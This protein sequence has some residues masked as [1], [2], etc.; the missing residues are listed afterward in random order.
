MIIKNG[1]VFE[2]DFRF[3]KRDV[4][5]ENGM[6]AASENELSNFDIVDATGHYVLPGLIDIHSHGACGHDFSDGDTEGLR[7]ILAYERSCGI[8]SYC[9]TS[10]TLPN[11]QLIHIFEEASKLEHSPELAHI[12]GFNMEGPFLDYKKKGA[13]KEEYIST[14]YV[15]FFQECNAASNYRIRLV[16]LAP[17]RKDSLSFIQELHEETNISLGHTSA[18]YETCKKAF[19]MGANHVTHLYNAMQPF[20]HRDPGLIGAAAENDSCMVELICDGIHIHESVVRATFKL[21]PHRVVL[22]SDSMRAVGLGN[23]TY[24]L[25]GQQV[26]VNGKLATLKDGT[27]AGSASNL[28]D[29]LKKAIAFG[30]PIPDA[31]AAATI[32]P[33]KSIGIDN[34]VGSLEPGKRADII[35]VTSDWQLLQVI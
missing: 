20:G 7:Q 26:N 33:A 23:G 5:I 29:C 13:H 32:N 25:G 27:I 8:T 3:T 6:I 12:A 18:D 34:V 15:Q 16:T 28:F 10:M 9:P 22:I 2:P 24:D 11:D 19:E 1:F 14:P 30:I 31:I 21:F 17:N 4:Y 35:L